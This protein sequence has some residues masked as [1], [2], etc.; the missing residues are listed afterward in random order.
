MRGFVMLV[1]VSHAFGLGDFK[2]P[3]YQWLA[4]YFNHVKW[5]GLIPWELIMPSFMFMIGTALP[6]ALARRK[7]R[8]EGFAGVMGHASIR[9]LKL[10][11]L[12]QF[13]TC[14]HAG[15][16]AYEPYETLTQLGLSYFVC[17]LILQQRF[18]W[19]AAAAAGLMLAN[20]GLYA[21]FP[22]SSG[23]FSGADNVGARFDT[24]VFQ[25]NHAWD[26]SSM[27]FLGSAVTVLFGAWAGTLLTTTRPAGSKLQ[28]LAAAAASCFVLGFALAPVNPMIHKAWTASFTFF[29]TGIVVLGL[30]VF[31]WLFD[32]K[33]WRRPAFPLVVVG[34]NSIFIYM[35]WQLFNGWIDR[36]AAIFTGRFAL[37]GAFG[38]AMQ[39]CLCAAVMWYA[40]HWL[41]R[42]GIF[43]KL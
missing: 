33:G 4:A 24:A 11:L 10:I 3:K 39:A 36:T 34:M 16:W 32:S 15:R 20:W 27:N 13:L 22:G 40:C 25:L 9:T 29:H 12:G 19:Q 37:A 23:P 35:L 26:W 2:D 43:L 1:L 21:A 31:F 7:E 6:F 17:F 28:I 18:R 5:E 30:A 8:G 14:Y 42:R 38:P 41:Y